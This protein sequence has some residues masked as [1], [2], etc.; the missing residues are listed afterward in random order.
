MTNLASLLGGIDLNDIFKNI[1][2]LRTLGPAALESL[3]NVVRTAASNDPAVKALLAALET[4][5][6]PIISIPAEDLTRLDQSRHSINIRVSHDYPRD[7]VD[8][9][10][11]PLPPP[12]TGIVFGTVLT[13][14][15]GDDKLA[16]GNKVW[17][18][19]GDK[20]KFT[21]TEGKIGDR[22]PTTFFPEILGVEEPDW[23]LFRT[24]SK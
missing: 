2:N 23:K 22:E 16:N 20:T 9:P 4:I 24:V 5:L 7:P 19:E 8:P 6:D 3:R 1:Q 13:G 11:P 17:R 10:P 15:P 14:D 18:A 12:P 21:V